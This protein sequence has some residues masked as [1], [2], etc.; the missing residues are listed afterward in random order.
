MKIII[1]T[2]LIIL[3]AAAVF[4]LPSCKDTVKQDPVKEVVPNAEAEPVSKY[5]NFTEERN[6]SFEMLKNFN[7][8]TYSV[9]W[10]LWIDGDIMLFD[11]YKKVGRY[12]LDH[13]K[14]SVMTMCDEKIPY[15]L[16][17]KW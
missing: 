6:V 14:D 11:S 2:I 16:T 17:K 12:N 5:K 10:F 4:F 9:S 3:L 7:D 1:Q 13:F 15:L 8:Q